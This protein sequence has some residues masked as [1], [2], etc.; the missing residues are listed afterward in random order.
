MPIRT[1]RGRSAVYRRLWAWPLRSPRH[2][3]AAII[4]L[5]VLA[6]VIAALLP[7]VRGIASRGSSGPGNATTANNGSWFATPTSTTTT[8]PQ[9]RLTSIPEHPTSAAPDPNAVSVAKAW[10]AAWVNHPV[11]MTSA[12][13]LDQLRPYTEP[14]FLATQMSTVDPSNIQAT[15]VTGGPVVMESYTSSE[16]IRLPTNGGDLDITV[17]NTPTGWLVSTYTGGS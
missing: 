12:Q 6:L 4:G 8:S 16:L 14:E 13:W 1:N 10:A 2:L 7:Q 3:L 17:V 9:T 5:A 15:A 11:G